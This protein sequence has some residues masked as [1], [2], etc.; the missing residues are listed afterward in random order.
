MYTMY[1]M[2]VYMRLFAA[3]A[4]KYL[5]QSLFSQEVAA[6]EQRE[7]LRA[8]R[9]R[10]VLKTAAKRVQWRRTYVAFME[11]VRH[12]VHPARGAGQRGPQ[13]HRW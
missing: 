1:I 4:P 7:Q 11:V 3:C 6:G 10:G 8:A 9:L 2:T 13:L 5:M 12:L